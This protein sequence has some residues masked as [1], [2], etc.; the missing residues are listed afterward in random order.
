MDETLGLID[1]CNFKVTLIQISRRRRERK[2]GR[3]E[4]KAGE[5]VMELPP[6][7]DSGDGT[8]KMQQF[9]EVRVVS[10]ESP[11]ICRSQ[12]TESPASLIRALGV[13][14]QTRKEQKD[15]KCMK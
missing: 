11:R 4:H 10:N 8:I 14:Q 3:D 5:E 7:I 1:F 13:L 2:G 15:Q 6:A 9:V 12:W